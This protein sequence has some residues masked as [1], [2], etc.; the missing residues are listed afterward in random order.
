MWGQGI[1]VVVGDG[2]WVLF[3]SVHTLYIYVLNAAL[4]VRRKEL[5]KEQQ[6]ALAERKTLSAE[7]GKL[8]RE[9]KVRRR[10]VLFEH[11]WMAD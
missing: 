2:F 11:A 10:L 9:K 6:G 3:L 5:V 1:W 7:I 8:M 4:N